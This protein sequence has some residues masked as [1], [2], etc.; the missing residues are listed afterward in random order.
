MMRRLVELSKANDDWMNRHPAAAVAAVS[1]VVLILMSFAENFQY[2]LKFSVA[3]ALYTY[4]TMSLLE[5]AGMLA[6]SPRVSIKRPM[7]LFGLS[8][9]LSVACFYLAS[10]G[11]LLMLWSFSIGSAAA[12]WLAAFFTKKKCD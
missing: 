1:I 3:M 10:S 11:M 9:L 5:L 6:N 4:A 8:A 7:A 12:V 2:A